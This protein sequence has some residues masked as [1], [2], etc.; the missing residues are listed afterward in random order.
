MCDSFSPI[1][2]VLVVVGVGSTMCINRLQTYNNTR[3]TIMSRNMSTIH[4]R[5]LF[6]STVSSQ[7]L[8]RSKFQSIPSRCEPRNY[9]G[10][11]DSDI[12]VT[13]ICTTHT[14]LLTVFPNSPGKLQFW[15]NVLHVSNVSKPR[16]R[17]VRTQHALPSSRIKD[18]RLTSLSLV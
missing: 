10:T 5:Q 2:P 12:L 9:F 13:N 16:I 18:Y 14:N 1:S 4:F 11:N 6:T 8:L 17:L 3:R 15:I 7:M